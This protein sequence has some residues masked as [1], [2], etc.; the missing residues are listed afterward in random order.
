MYKDDINAAFRWILYH[1]DIA[2]AFATMLQHILCI[3]VWL[4]FGE[5]S[6]PLSSAIPPKP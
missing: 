6:P 1:P 2:P 3:Q 5:G 4:I